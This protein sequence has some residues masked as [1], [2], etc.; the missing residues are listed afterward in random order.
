MSREFPL[1]KREL[2]GPKVL[3]K[4]LCFLIFCGIIVTSRVTLLLQNVMIPFQF[5]VFPD[6]PHPRPLPVGRGNVLEE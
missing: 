5:Y 6:P 1:L 3:C 2:T 4:F